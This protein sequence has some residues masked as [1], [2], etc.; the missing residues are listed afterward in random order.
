MAKWE[1]TSKLA[2]FMDRHLV[3]PMLEFLSGKPI[4]DEVDITRSK[5]EL[6]ANTDMVDFVMDLH[7]ILHPGQQMP[8]ALQDKRMAVV[9][10]YNKLSED[11]Q[12]IITIFHNPDVERHIQSSRD[13]KL[14]VDHLTANH[15]FKPEMVD[16]CYNFAK[17]LYEIGNYNG[18]ISPKSLLYLT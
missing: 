16:S 12:A 10:K 6:F 7:K 9:D 5:Y 3:A 2:P 1:L 4:Y 11:T 13:T 17:C 8:T 18:T 14:L 15:N